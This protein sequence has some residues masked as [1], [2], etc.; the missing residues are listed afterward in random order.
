MQ[1][2]LEVNIKVKFDGTDNIVT[3][4][5]GEENKIIEILT[6]LEMARNTLVGL[7]G[8]K[9]TKEDEIIELTFK[10]ISIISFKDIKG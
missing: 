10:D 2:N 7:A 9:A 1:L 3:V 4:E 8:K 5:T 6:T